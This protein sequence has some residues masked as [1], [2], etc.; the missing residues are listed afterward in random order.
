[1]A[2]NK[3]LIN[4]LFRENVMISRIILYTILFIFIQQLVFAQD[5]NQDN[6]PHWRGPLATG[7]SPSGNPPL[8][9]SE[10]QNIKWKVM[11]P[12]KGHATPI[13]WGD[14]IFVLTSIA[15][16]V[17]EP[18]LWDKLVIYSSDED[19][20]I[21]K[22]NQVH[23]F[24][25]LCIHRTSG[26]I[27]WQTTVK[28]ELPKDG[29]HKTATWASNSPVTDGKFVYAYFGSRGLYCLDYD[30]N[31]I[32]QK[33]LGPLEK[34]EQ[35]GEGSSPV[36]DNDH[37]FI[38]RDHEGDSFLHAFDK[39]TG[40]V[41]WK[42]ARDETTTWSTPCI[43]TTNS[44]AQVITSGN[45]SICSYDAQTGEVIW[46]CEWSTYRPVATPLAGKNL[47]YAMNAFRG[48]HLIAIDFHEARGNI[49][50]SNSI[51]WRSVKNL[52][53][54]P[55]PL[56]HEDKL[57]FLKGSKGNISCLNAL[58]GEV[59]YTGKKMEELE[60][61]FASPVA[62][63]NRVYISSLNGKTCVI[64]HGEQFDILA[65]NTLDEKFAASPV[66]SANS[67]FL[68]GENYLYCISE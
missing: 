11:I 64:Q 29:V 53:Y 9:W 41:L 8:N 19:E 21:L 68:R 46:E 40:S 3:S 33:D 34:A 56:L 24:A 55:S 49:S 60:E 1:V 45:N 4:P 48:K 10:T 5:S 20:D 12:G 13:I 16:P 37:L 32:W 30:G 61:V 54:T 25:V 23:Q 63:Q 7:A 2:K 27:L 26:E 39:N 17:E 15:G 22:T 58:N 38:Q 6:W 43:V 59:F 14:R 47:V 35:M 66:I 52:P 65:V 67:I 18:G 28:E 57:Y 51:I 36:L 42:S 62:A 50:E 31:I 44:G